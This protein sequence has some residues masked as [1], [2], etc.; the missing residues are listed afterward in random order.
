M[1]C[2]QII[3]MFKTHLAGLINIHLA[4][5]SPVVVVYSNKDLRLQA[6]QLKP[7]V[8]YDALVLRLP[9]THTPDSRT[10][11]FCLHSLHNNHIDT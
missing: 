1:A 5:L 6:V 7:P 9:M 2:T 8:L 10:R 4:I 11:I 3:I